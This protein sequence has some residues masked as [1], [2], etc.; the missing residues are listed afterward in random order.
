VDNQLDSENG[1]DVDEETYSEFTPVLV[2]KKSPKSKSRRSSVSAES[3]DP[4]KLKEQLSQIETI[5][6]EPHVMSNLLVV[7]SKSPLLRALDSEQKEKIVNAF[8]G[9]VSFARGENIITQG[10][11]G[12]VFYLL[13][14]GEVE[15][16]IN[17]NSKSNKGTSTDVEEVLVHTYKSGDSFGELAI[18]YNTPRAATCRAKTD[19]MV[20]ALDRTSFKAIVVSASMIKRETYQQFLKGVP[21]LES[22]TDMEIMT[23][24]DVLVE[25][26][27]HHNDKICTQGEEG[28]YFYIIKSGSAICTQ[29]NEET[30]DEKI[31]ANLVHGNYFGEIAL[32]TNKPRQAT[33]IAQEDMT[34]LAID[35]ATFTRIFGS[36]DE[37][38]KRNIDQYTKYSTTI[39]RKEEE[40]K[41]A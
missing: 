40:K 16:Y 12:K 24:A 9:P 21:I 11:D 28:N 19:C 39:S 37:I 5:P 38:L 35:R 23:L 2:S 26:N 10:D 33:V 41:E 22:L 14:Q 36:L 6:K 34:V 25:E 3:A 29:Y 18:M 20:W 27:F 15:V 1:S 31:V 17:N 32:L 8:S 7:V 13:E 30:D 4:N